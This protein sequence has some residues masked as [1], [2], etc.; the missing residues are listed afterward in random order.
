MRK[1]RRIV[2]IPL[3]LCMLTYMMKGG[4]YV[5]AETRETGTMPKMVI[6]TTAPHSI[7]QY[8]KPSRGT[9]GTMLF[10]KKS[11]EW[12]VAYCLDFGKTPPK[13]HD[14]NTL[15]TKQSEE[16]QAALT[17]GYDEADD[18]PSPEQKAK[19][20]ATQITVWN[21][22]EGIHG[23]EKAVKAMEE[24]CN[25]LEAPKEAM[26]YYKQLN[27]KMENYKKM[28]D[29]ISEKKEDAETHLLK[30]NTETK[31]YEKRFVD[32]NH[33]DCKLERRGNGNLKLECVD[34]AKKEYCLYTEKGIEN[35]TVE[36]VRT[37]EY[38]G[39]RSCLVWGVE[40]AKYQRLATANPAAIK[41][42]T[43]GYMSAKTEK[44]KIDLMKIESE[45]G[46]TKPQI[47]NSTFAGTVYD[48][49]SK[50]NDKFL[51][52][53]TI[54]ED[55]TASLEGIK[56]GSYYLIEREAPHGYT[57]DEKKYEFTFP[58][59][60][61]KESIISKEEVIRGDIE[62]KKTESAVQRPM[63]GIEF[64]ITNLETGEKVV[65]CTDENGTATT[66]SE[67][68]PRGRLV[69][70][71]YQVAETKYPEGYIPIKPFEVEITNE[72]EVLTY[73]L[74]N[75]PVKG[76]IQIKKSDAGTKE[77]LSGVGFEIIAKEDIVAEDGSIR[78][79]KGEVVEKLVTE[80]GMAES[81]ELYLGTYEVKETKALPG[82]ELPKQSYEVCLKYQGEETPV[83]MESLS[84]ENHKKEIVKTGDTSMVRKYLGLTFLGGIA[85]ALILIKSNRRKIS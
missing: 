11:N 36:L 67:D 70:G 6:I 7:T 77:W 18:T 25:V 61:M 1:I 48:V 15:P 46:E 29:F 83:V 20:A 82:Y 32:Q 65:I 85:I 72:S 44:G 40:D 31:R 34:A 21:I 22:M 60:G 45:T 37:D 68:Y 56:E 62:I 8:S 58:T 50:E 14:I 66:K 78:V 47:G 52:F 76:R 71:K 39:I 13:G 69:Y 49:Y 79:K 51:A 35:E 63:Q 43:K 54:G 28:P 74:E 33:L 19:Y 38:G 64:T 59:E 16:L 30:W 41:V 5:N 55:G 80:N 17:F 10:V 9:Y 27:E 73:D 12:K 57:L 81:S 53:L 42:G 24:F 84:I 23:T 26:N 2:L 75:I 4:Y 3:F